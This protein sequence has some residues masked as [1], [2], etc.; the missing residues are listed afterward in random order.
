MGYIILGLGNPDSEYEHTRHN[1]GRDIVRAFAVKNGFPEW[2]MDKKL[3]S[4][5]TEGKIG[6]TPVLLL[7]P[8]T[9]MNRSGNAVKSL[10][11]SKKKAGELIVVQDEM[12]MPL[13]KM[14]ISFGR[15]SGG[16]RGIDSLI[17]AVKTNEFVRVRVGI[18]GSTA[19]GVAKKPATEEAVI[20]FVLGKWKGDQEQTFKKISKRVVDALSVIVTDGRE[21]AMGEFN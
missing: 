8:E 3:S 18:S 17:K 19:K 12:D 6:K 10:V 11:T 21:R 15:N 14:K 7:L 1:A 2:K 13:G 16:H 4:L 20:K 9:S 5:R